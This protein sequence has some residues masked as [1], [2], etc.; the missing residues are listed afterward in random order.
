MDNLFLILD[1]HD[2]DFVDFLIDDGNNSYKRVSFVEENFLELEIDTLNHFG[3][4]GESIKEFLLGFIPFLI[5]IV[6]SSLIVFVGIKK[7]ASLMLLL[8]TNY[9]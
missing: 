6:P 5:A 8:I 4:L 2:H 1:T 7:L 3:F 9:S